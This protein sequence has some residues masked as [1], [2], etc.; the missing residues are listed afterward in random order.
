MYDIAVIGAGVNG[1]CIAYELA[2]VYGN[3]V[4]FEKDG[5]ASGGSGAAGAFIAPKFS[6]AGELKEILHHAYLYS[7]KFYEDVAPSSFFKTRL[8]HIAKDAKDDEIL[9]AYKQSTTIPLQEQNIYNER[10]SVSIDAGLVEPISLCKKL[11]DGVEVIGHRVERLEFVDGCWVIDGV[12]QAKKVVVA[13]GA[14]KKIINE[15]YLDVI[16]GIWGHR[17]DVK[18]STN[19]P[20]SLHQFVSVSPSKDGILAIG[21][22]HNVHYHPEDSSCEYNFQDGRDELLQK[23]SRTIKLD[24]VEVIKDYVGLRSGS[25]DYLPIIGEIVDA[26]A[27]LKCCKKAVRVK[28]PQYDNFIYHQDLYM[29]N[30]SG[31]YGFVLA[32][33][34]AKIL[35]ESI[36]SKSKIPQTITPARFFAR[37]AKRL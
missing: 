29:I 1:S 6:K 3:V 15:P 9:K 21:A 14:Y 37:W 35:A 19:N 32:P 31:G 17:I 4:V 12:F 33:Y 27:T 26:D 7:M 23:A 8:I 28:K 24:D 30:G 16:R 34:L 5:I 36:V 10:E 25:F 13:I 20:Y 22:T 18:T 11:L 2:K